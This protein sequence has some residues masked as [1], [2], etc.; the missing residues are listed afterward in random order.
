MHMGPGSYSEA[1]S[2]TSAAGEGTQRKGKERCEEPP[3]SRQSWRDITLKC[4]Y[5]N[6]DNILGKLNEMKLKTVDCDIIGIVESWANDA[7]NDP[8]LTLSGY[9]MFRIDKKEANGVGGWLLLDTKIN[10][11]PRAPLNWPSMDSSSHCGAQSRSK[12]G[13][14][15][16][17]V[18]LGPSSGSVN[19]DK[20]LELL[21]EVVQRGG[22]CNFLIMGDFNYPLIDYLQNSV[23]AGPDSA[24]AKFLDTTQDLL[25]FQHVM[26]PTRMRWTIT[27]HTQLCFHRLGQRNWDQ[28]Q[29][30]SPTWK[31]DHV[32]WSLFQ[33]G[34]SNWWNNVAQLG[35]SIDSSSLQLWS[36]P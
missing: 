30:P 2:E 34:Q 19:N 5:S 23:S 35:E 6:A 29:G 8:G 18:R 22:Y 14:C 20:L 13:S 15:Q 36:V 11:K 27:V 28:V 32:T 24:V 4:F 16:I 7:V 12:Q 9:N 17:M 31:S 26:E 33:V 10:V 1:E 25:L 21:R 3:D